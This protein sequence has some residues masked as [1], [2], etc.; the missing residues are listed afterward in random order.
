MKTP[1]NYALLQELLPVLHKHDIDI[2]GVHVV[3]VRRRFL[4]DDGEHHVEIVIEGR[5][6]KEA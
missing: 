1:N 6:R 4:G 2:D 5:L 3:P